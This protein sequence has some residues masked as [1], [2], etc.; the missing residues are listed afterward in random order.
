MR[1]FAITFLA[2]GILALSMALSSLAVNFLASF[3]LMG[4]GC[5]LC[6]AGFSLGL[7]STFGMNKS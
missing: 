2:F 1:R 3:F 7:A 5:G 4:I 6:M